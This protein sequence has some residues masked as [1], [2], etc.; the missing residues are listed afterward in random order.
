MWPGPACFE[1]RDVVLSCCERA[2]ACTKGTMAAGQKPIRIAYM[3]LQTG[4]VVANSVRKRSSKL[5]QCRTQTSECGV[6]L[7]R[8]RQLSHYSTCT[9]TQ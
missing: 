4:R 7:R 5:V 2:A 8:Y 3:E 1:D 6:T 9:L